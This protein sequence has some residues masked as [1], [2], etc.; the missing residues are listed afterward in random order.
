MLHDDVVNNRTTTKCLLVLCSA[1]TSYYT[2]TEALGDIT[3]KKFSYM[4]T[5]SPLSSSKLLGELVQWFRTLTF[6][7]WQPELGLTGEQSIAK[8]S[9]DLV[10]PR[11]SET[12]ARFQ[13]SLSFLLFA[14]FFDRRGRPVAAST[15]M[16]GVCR[17]S[18]KLLLD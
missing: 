7:G 6:Q 14:L 1:R 5:F 2:Y 18:C 3:H 16:L 8:R 9:H 12:L 10:T 15:V 17:S 13:H 11:V 4:N